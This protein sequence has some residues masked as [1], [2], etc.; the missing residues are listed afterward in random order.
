MAAYDVLG[1]N[2]TNLGSGT[3]Y[4][5]L[6]DARDQYVMT[7]TVDSITRRS[8]APLVTGTAAEGRTLTLR[9]ANAA[10]SSLT[11]AQFRDAVKTLFDP[12]LNA[13]GTRLLVIEGDDGTTDV[14]TGCY[15]VQW[16]YLSQ[17]VDQYIITLW[18]PSGI[19]Q[20][21]TVTTS[22]SNPAT[23]TN[24]GNTL[25]YPI[26]E[27]TTGTHVT[28]RACTVTGGSG[29]LI[30]YPVKFT[31][32]AG[33]PIASSSTANP[34]VVSTSPYAHGLTTGNSV[35]ITGH[36]DATINGTHTITVT[37]N[38]AFS[39]PVDGA[40]GGGGTGG[41]VILASAYDAGVATALSGLSASNFAVFVQSVPVPFY[42]MNTGLA[43]YVW[44]LVDTD[45]DGTTS[46]KVDILYG[47]DISNPLANTLLDGGLEWDAHTDSTN[48]LWSWNDWSGVKGNPNRPGSWRAGLTG[49]HHPDTDASYAITT[50]G[51]GTF[52][53][54]IGAAGVY[55]NS[56]DSIIMDVGAR[57]TTL[58]NLRRIT[59]NLDGTNA[60]AFVRYRLAG[61]RDW[62]DAWTSTTNATVTTDVSVGNAVEI[63]IGIE[64]HGATADPATLTMTPTSDVTLSL[65]GTPTVVIGAATNYD[66][67][68]GGA[69]EIEGRSIT[70]DTYMVPDG[71]LTIDAE[72]RGIT[73]SVAGPF[74]WL[75]DEEAIQFSHPDQWYVLSPGSNDV[76][77]GT[78]DT[79]VVVK[80][81][82]SYA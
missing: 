53:I 11:A 27:L 1:F 82:A 75:D 40:T 58:A 38:V 25:A 45:S 74:Y 44:T 35:T 73:S 47:G 52:V 22:A 41:S 72:T 61:S 4:D 77:N 13:N 67:H 63:A 37:S 66:I 56:A 17:G 9:I 7:A 16:E 33:I 78:D 69:I 55:D 48:A 76:T 24:A 21:T 10:G 50:T 51:A 43:T 64:N 54:S 23:V 5:A 18:S 36:S 57:G 20:A 70:F 59:A 65:S 32:Q 6:M 46:T 81:W 3:N 28:R 30:G 26:I 15:V 79:D 34:A 71:T 39:I 62:L 42:V 68:T 12:R 80:H 8:A 2:G 29:G 19:W 49:S 31:L 14:Q 60:R